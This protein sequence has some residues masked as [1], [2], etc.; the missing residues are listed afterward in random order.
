MK[1]LM[2]TAPNG[3]RIRVNANHII[4]YEKINREQDIGTYVIFVDG[5]LKVR[6]VPEDIDLLI[7]NDLVCLRDIT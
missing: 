2:L 7:G 6:E 3:T 1:F 4:S 5:D